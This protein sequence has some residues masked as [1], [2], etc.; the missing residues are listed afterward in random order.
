MQKTEFGP[1]AKI[2]M[3]KLDLEPKIEKTS[4]ECRRFK[5][6]IMLLIK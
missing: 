3:V 1:W 5:L 6:L 2:D 4:Q